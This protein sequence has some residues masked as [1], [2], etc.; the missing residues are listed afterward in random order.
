MRSPNV[1]GR[2]RQLKHGYVSPHKKARKEQEAKRVQKKLNEEGKLTVEQREQVNSYITETSPLLKDHIRRHADETVAAILD[3]ASQNTQGS[4]VDTVKKVLPS[5]EDVA[6]LMEGGMEEEEA[7]KFLQGTSESTGR[8]G[9]KFD[10][11]IAMRYGSDV[12]VDMDDVL[13]TYPMTPEQKSLKELAG[14]LINSEDVS[15]TDAPT[16][17]QHI[18][19]PPKVVDAAAV[20]RESYNQLN[21]IYNTPQTDPEVHLSVDLD[22]IMDLDIRTVAKVL[23]AAGLKLTFSAER[24]DS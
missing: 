11:E 24:K 9:V 2:H 10:P 5:P 23:H 21:T 17:V 12:G 19:D 3:G 4:I 14:K 18:S 1:L 7:Q 20:Y 15:Y 6:L 8:D 22:Q 16:F 13:V